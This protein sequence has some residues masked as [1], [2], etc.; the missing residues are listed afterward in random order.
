[1]VSVAHV[2]RELRRDKPRKGAICGGFSARV[3]KT[4]ENGYH[5]CQF[6]KYTFF[7]GDPH[8][9]AAEPVRRPCHSPPAK[10][11]HRVV[12]GPFAQPSLCGRSR[13][14]EPR[15]RWHVC[16]CASSGVEMSRAHIWRALWRRGPAPC[17]RIARNHWRVDETGAECCLF[18]VVVDSGRSAR[19]DAA[20]RRRPGRTRFRLSGISLYD[21]S[22]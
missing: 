4:G 1:M 12:G 19:C 9:A 7:W 8:P 15:E 20:R 6:V 17:C 22:L 13:S 11:R 5:E 2:V 10:D 16:V 3:D 18:V 14:T 21:V